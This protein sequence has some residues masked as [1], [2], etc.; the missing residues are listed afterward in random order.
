LNKVGAWLG[1]QSAVHAMTD[2]T[3]FGLAGHALEMARGAK[4]R[5]VI[6]T[7]AV[8]VLEEA[9]GLAVEGV[10]PSGA[11]RNMHSYGEAVNFKDEW[12]IDRQLVFTDPQTNGGLLI[13]VAPE[14]ARFICEQLAERGCSEV[15]IIGEVTAK[16]RTEASLVFTQSRAAAIA[17]TQVVLSACA[18]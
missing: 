2:V 6:D 11:Y 1:S 15:A 16:R 7:T 12:D 3:G 18:D 9:W 8:P 4:V 5:L 13:A 14:Q 10:V 17:K